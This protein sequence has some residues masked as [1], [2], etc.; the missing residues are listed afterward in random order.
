MAA[1]I[2]SAVVRPNSE[3]L[4]GEVEIDESYLGG[5]EPGKPGRAAEKKTII[6]AAVEKRGRG[7]GRVRLGLVADVSADALTTF[8]RK[9]L[10][11]DE[12]AHT[13]GWRGYAR[14]GRTASR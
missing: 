8:V 2:R 5:P 11:D 12:T 7:C 14:L 13:D 6:A 3:P 1:E 10:G 4:A 9:H